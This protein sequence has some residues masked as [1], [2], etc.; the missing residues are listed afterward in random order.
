MAYLTWREYTR[1][2]PVCLGAILVIAGA[3]LA[4]L[5]NS[6]PA[7]DFVAGY[8]VYIGAAIAIVGLLFIIMGFVF[9]KKKRDSVLTKVETKLDDTPPPPPPPD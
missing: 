1:S 2:G 9:T 3:I 5:A 4:L 8:T 7:Y 6:N